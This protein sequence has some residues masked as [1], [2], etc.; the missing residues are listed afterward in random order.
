MIEFILLMKNKVLEYNIDEE[1]SECI[2]KHFVKVRD[3]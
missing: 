3:V 1:C 2:T